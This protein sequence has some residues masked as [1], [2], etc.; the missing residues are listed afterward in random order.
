MI[1]MINLTSFNTLNSNL[2]RAAA[3][4]VIV[5][6]AAVTAARM[7]E[8]GKALSKYGAGEQANIIRL[9]RAE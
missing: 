4:Q 2:E 6:R 3:N 5:G 8:E 1:D 7:A 9:G